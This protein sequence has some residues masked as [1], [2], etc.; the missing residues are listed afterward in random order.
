MEK[1]IGCNA[2]AYS[3]REKGYS[4]EPI[5]DKVWQLVNQELQGDVLDVGSGSG[6]WLRKL[7]QIPKI[8]KIFSVDIVDDGASQIDGV[9]FQI[10]DISYSS[11][12]CDDN[13]LDWIFSIEV[14][15][16]LANPRNLIQESSRCLKQSG[17]LVITTPCNDSLRSKLSLLIRG[18]FPAFCDRDYYGS[19]HISPILELDLKRMANEAFF[20]RVNFFYPLPGLIPTTAVAWQRIFPWLQGKLWSDCLIAILEK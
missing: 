4:P 2:E 14:I 7:K 13:S 20:E 15:E 10:V 17:K 12:P 9:D 3:L 16:H 11:I 8:G 1:I 6:L 18:Y 19:G 5:K